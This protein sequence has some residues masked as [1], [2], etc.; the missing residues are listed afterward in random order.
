MAG[1][2]VGG[3]RHTGAT[4]EAYEH[5][6]DLAE[7]ALNGLDAAR[8]AIAARPVP[9][10]A[11]AGLVAGAA[12][13]VLGARVGAAPAAVP[14]DH[15]LGLLPAAGYRITDVGLGLGLLGAVVAL[16]GCWVLTIHVAHRARLSA[17]Q[18]W[19]IAGVWAT[20]FLLGPPL[21]T[22]DAFGYVARGLI[23]RAGHDPYLAAPSTL[24]DLRIVDAID[25][26]WRG[27]ESTD[28]PLATLLCHFVVALC[29]GA[30]VPALLL[31]RAIAVGSAI[32]IGALAGELAGPRR[33]T[34]LC[35]TVLNPAVLLFVVSAAGLTGLLMALLLA[36][37]VAARRRH[38]LAAVA[39]VAL[40][41]A[42]KPVALLGLPIVIAYHLLG[43]RPRAGARLA[44]R[45][46]AV[47]LAVL[48]A[49]TLA[50]PDGLGLLRNLGD[51]FHED[52][53]FTPSSI[54]A[55][56]IGLVVP[57]AYDDLLTGARIAATV[58]AAVVICALLA[59]RRLRALEDTLGDSLL[60]AAVLG[61]VLYPKFLL[62]GLLCLAPTARATH[63]YWVVALSC[64]A[65]VLTPLGLGPRGGQV[66]AGIVLV[67]IAI[68]LAAAIVRWRWSARAALDPRPPRRNGRDIARAWPFLASRR[69]QVD[70]A[71]DD[72]QHRLRL[73]HRERGA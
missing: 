27:A 9:A 25:P 12:V 41:A 19:T 70:A 11:A 31:F 65:C 39:L 64:A 35:L 18:V 50:V 4:G 26:T 67:V 30:T 10:L 48:A 21:M 24:G 2:R 51:A 38:W 55:S 49:A 46:A 3:V 7:K 6:N 72:L 53:A 36:A 22:T 45:D 60:T 66:A 47:A 52:V 71:H 57:A 34:A 63:R 8:R 5:M 58:A 17:H 59:T 73:H 23:A 28:G 29:G 62:W 20:P 13:V 54:G 42:I 56:V 16:L 40:A 15:W 33:R 32:A 43:A 68:A 37:L 1:S 14:I 61:P 69:R 44:V